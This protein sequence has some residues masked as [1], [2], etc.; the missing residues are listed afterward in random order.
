M[1]KPKGRLLLCALLVYAAC[2]S[3]VIGRSQGDLFRVVTFGTSLTSENLW[4]PDLRDKLAHCL[5]GRIEVLNRGKSGMAS[6]WGAEKV[7]RVIASRPNAVIIEFAIN[8]AFQPYGISLEE[9][10]RNTIHIVNALRKDLPAA[11]IWLMTTNPTFEPDR[12][13]LADYYGQYRRVA[14]ELD[15]GL[16]DLFPA[17]AAAMAADAGERLMPDHLHPTQE[18]YREVSISRIARQITDGKCS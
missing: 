12:P 14:S 3:T 5:Q 16:I 8:D 6:P 7:R 11:R 1:A 18:G 15:V 13:N 9:S 2:F 10:Y 4:Q 17:W